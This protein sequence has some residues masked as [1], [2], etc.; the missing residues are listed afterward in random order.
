M[1]QPDRLTLVLRAVEGGSLDHVL[2][3]AQVGAHVSAGR[4]LAVI[5]S[6][7]QGDL[8]VELEQQ[9]D[10]HLRAMGV[11]PL[12]AAHA[13]EMLGLLRLIDAKCGGLDALLAHGIEPSEPMWQES[14]EAM[15][16]IGPLL[17][18]L[19]PALGDDSQLAFSIDDH[20]RMSADSRRYRWLRAQDSATDPVMSVTRWTQVD[21][22]RATGAAIAGEDLDDAVDAALRLEA[23]DH[24]AAQEQQP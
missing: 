8:Q 19:A 20:V 10:L 2:P 17:D 7:S 21:S 1:T 15:E 23:R 12:L 11:P 22:N 18:K 16:S 14:R 6:A 4:G 13:R 9:A 5:A 24:Q 3:F